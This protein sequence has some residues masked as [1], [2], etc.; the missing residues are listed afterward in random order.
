MPGSSWNV[1]AACVSLVFFSG[2]ACAAPADREAQAVRT[3]RLRQNAAI[4]SHDL[5]A[6]AAGWTEDVTICRALGT[7]VAG[8]AAYRQL[9]ETDDPASADTL[10]YERIPADVE[11]SPVWNLAFETGTWTGRDHGGKGAA[12]I[13]GRYSAQWVKRDGRWLIR[14]E[15]FVALAGEGPGLKF[16]A[17]P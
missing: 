7:Q 3:A 16:K 2:L 10:V 17:V 12:L 5:D 11:V 15:V 1:S 9:F 14:A 8:K 4:A 13:R 6:V